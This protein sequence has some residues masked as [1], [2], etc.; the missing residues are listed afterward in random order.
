MSA[1]PAIA[2]HGMVGD[3][4]TAALVSSDGTIDWWCTPRFDS[5]RV[6]ASL[7]DSER[8]GYCRLSAHLPGGQEPVVR[9]L[10]LSDPAVLVTRFMAPGG[11]GEVADFMTP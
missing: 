3:L 10:Y 5:P 8:G 1:Y 11:V 7:L 4:Q 2:D 6:F 9:Q